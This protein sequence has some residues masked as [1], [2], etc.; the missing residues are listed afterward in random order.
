MLRSG[1]MAVILLLACNQ[2]A[3]SALFCPQDTS[4]ETEITVTVYITEID[5]ESRI[6]SASELYGSNCYPYV[7]MLQAFDDFPPTPDHPGDDSQPYSA[8]TLVK[9]Q[10]P[11]IGIPGLANKQ[12][13]RLT[14][15]ERTPSGGCVWA[16]CASPNWHRTSNS[17]KI[18][19][20]PSPVGE[21]DRSR[22]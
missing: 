17:V 4:A 15:F 19:A 8:G 2:L 14:E 6:Y 20:R 10:T 18:R 16:G 5:T 22:R 13:R 1:L 12:A 9:V 7:T 3:A 21:N 11:W